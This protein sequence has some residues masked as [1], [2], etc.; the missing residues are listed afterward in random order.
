MGFFNFIKSYGSVKAE[1]AG[2]GVM[3]TLAGWDPEGA[4]EAD[5]K[6]I[7]RELTK[8]TKETAEALRTAKREREEAEEINKLY[9][10]KLSG[11]EILEA[12]KEG[13]SPEE[14][15]KVEAVIEEE[16]AKLEAMQEDIERE[17]QEAAEAEEYQ[18]ELEE[19]CRI[20]ANKLKTARS[21]L[22]K[23]KNAMKSAHLKKK[24]AEIAAERANKVAGLS[25]NL[26]KLG[27]ALE[28]MNAKAV[29]AEQDA[30]AIRMKSRLLKPA[31]TS[32]IMDNAVKEAMG[33][34]TSALSIKDRIAALKR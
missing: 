16:V 29:E 7:D 21:Q 25:N 27:S 10:I 30:E 18:K 26:H 12:R 15:A 20:T 22:N 33:Q 9:N 3:K 13:L 14:R 19:L 11:I 34:K 1:D 8:I 6:T 5:I 32:S 4:S 23:A 24:R 17:E 2:N 31:N 28:A